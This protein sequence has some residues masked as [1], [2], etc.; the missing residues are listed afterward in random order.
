MHDYVGF[1]VGSGT[2]EDIEIMDITRTNV[3]FRQDIVALKKL[4][5]C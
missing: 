3:L 2:F 1:V 4:C 5:R